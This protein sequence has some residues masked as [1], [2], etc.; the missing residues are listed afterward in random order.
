MYAPRL[1]GR[2]ILFA[3]AFALSGEGQ[4]PPMDPRP[5]KANGDLYGDPLPKGAVARLGA[6]RIRHPRR[7]GVGSGVSQ[8]RCKAMNS[9]EN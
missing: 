9:T 8:D 3:F 6:V 1:Q 7:G 5:A 4:E 2:A